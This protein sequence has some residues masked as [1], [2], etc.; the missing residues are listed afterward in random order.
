MHELFQV[1]NERCY[2]QDPGDIISRLFVP[3]RI[4]LKI[5]Y[6]PNLVLY[7]YCIDIICIGISLFNIIETADALV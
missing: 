5:C 1:F 3:S 2:T 7:A 6:F 4:I